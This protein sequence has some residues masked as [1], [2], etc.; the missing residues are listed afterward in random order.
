MTDKEDRPTGTT[1][2]KSYN[3][4]KVALAYQ[5]I[6]IVI[7]IGVFYWSISSTLASSE[8]SNRLLET[9]QKTL[10]AQTRP[11]HLIMEYQS[12]IDGNIFHD[13]NKT[14][15]TGGEPVNRDDR[16]R[17]NVW[18]TGAQVAENVTVSL[19]FNPVNAEIV[20]TQKMQKCRDVVCNFAPVH[21]NVMPIRAIEPS[22]FY[23]ILANYTLFPEVV[24][25]LPQPLNITFAVDYISDGKMVKM[26]ATYSIMKD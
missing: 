15:R 2:K 8:K 3:L 5:G 13:D 16:I 14:Y 18:N 9:A 26:N 19:L 7:A 24:A 4:Q 23:T 12:E 20:D 22:G 6:A 21:S 25:K 10:E 11:A 1:Q 17:I